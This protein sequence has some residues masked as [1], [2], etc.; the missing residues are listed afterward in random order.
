MKV[1][2]LGV[3]EA[4]DSIPNTSILV[5]SSANILLDCGYSI[6]PELWKYNSNPEYLDA[7]FLSHSHADHTFGLPA[8]LM[9]MCS[10]DRKK[11]LALICQPEMKKYI[12][13]MIELGYRGS[14]K[15]IRG[16][17][18]IGYLEAAASRP[19]QFADLK[20]S[21]ARPRHPV[22]VTAIRIDMGSKSL[23]YSSDGAIT[24]ETASLYRNADMLI[25]EAYLASGHVEGHSSI[26]DV[27]SMASSIGVRKLALVHINR[28]LAR[29]KEDLLRIARPE[30][31]EVLMPNSMDYVEL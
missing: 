13:D 6:P 14:L 9:R 7:I 27:I 19:L 16:K 17:F 8:V 26:S 23:C 15:K 21:F 12:E 28:E 24:E 18:G 4:F 3:G 1:I 29:K 22:N 11:P 5:E 10:E 25:H 20:L 31:I 2:F 30:G